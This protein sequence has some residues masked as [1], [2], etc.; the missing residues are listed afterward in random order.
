MKQ[1][2]YSVNEAMNGKQKPKQVDAAEKEDIDV[3]TERE[4]K[5]KEAK[6]DAK[7]KSKKEGEEVTEVYIPEQDIFVTLY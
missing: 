4:D 3:K 1:F 6:K 5:K 7:K 2:N